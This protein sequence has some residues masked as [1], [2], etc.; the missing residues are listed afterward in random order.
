MGREAGAAGA[1]VMPA[2]RSYALNAAPASVAGPVV[3]VSS[4]STIPPHLPAPVPIPSPDHQQVHLSVQEWQTL[5]HERWD[6][7]NNKKFAR[8]H[9]STEFTVENDPFTYR[10]NSKG[11]I[12][13]IYDAQRCYN[14]TGTRKGLSG[15]PLTL[16]GEPTFAGTPY[17]Y[18]PGPPHRTVV[19]IEMAG[20][21][22]GDFKLANEAAGLSNV[23][24]AQGRRADEAPR[25][26]TWHHRDDF[27][28]N[29]NPP[30]Y[31]KCTME[32]V[33]QRAHNKTFVHRGS[34]DQCNKYF[35]K[36]LYE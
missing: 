35:G 15:V 22:P 16:N 26:Y 14:I 20:N 33:E 31:G 8:Q 19:V 29:S 34:C 4:S 10:V 17:T 36:K 2:A 25:G 9:R 24:K 7:N 32:L 18:P 30:P 12:D 23:V 11:K 28:P 3:A 13:T 5:V 6:R 21:R 1:F 27:K